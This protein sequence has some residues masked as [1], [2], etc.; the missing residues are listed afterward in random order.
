MCGAC[1]GRAVVRAKA[2]ARAAFLPVW[3]DAQAAMVRDWNE[4]NAGS[5]ICSAR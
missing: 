1:R 3:N 2:F 5:K 4:S